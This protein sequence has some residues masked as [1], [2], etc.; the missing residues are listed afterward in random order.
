[1]GGFPSHL[2]KVSSGTLAG[3]CPQ[4]LGHRADRQGGKNANF[5]LSCSWPMHQKCC[6][7]DEG[8][9]V[10]ETTFTGSREF[11]MLVD[12]GVIISQSPEPQ[13]VSGDQLNTL[14]M[15]YVTSFVFSVY[16]SQVVRKISQLQKDK[17]VTEFAPTPL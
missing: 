2:D 17:L 11:I 7:N 14:W 1:M 15:R 12:S 8:N 5:G 16:G 6:G 10:I 9:K 13:S 4:E 3:L